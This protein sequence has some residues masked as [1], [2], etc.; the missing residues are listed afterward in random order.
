MYEESY[1][2]AAKYFAKAN[3]YEESLENYWLFLNAEIMKGVSANTPDIITQIANLKDNVKGAKVKIDICQMAKTKPSLRDFYLVLDEAC[4]YLSNNEVERMYHF[5]WQY[6]I[7]QIISKLTYEKNDVHAMD[8]IIKKRNE[9]KEFGI[10]LDT[11]KLA[12][13]AYSLGLKDYAILFWE[14]LDKTMR[15]VEYYKAKVDTLSYPKKME[16]MEAAQGVN[17]RKDLLSEYHMNKSVPLNDY[18]KNILCN[19]I[20]SEKA[21]EYFRE[22]LPYMLR[23]SLTMEATN[24]LL[25]EA[26]SVYKMIEL[27]VDVLKS[28]VAAKLTDLSTWSTPKTKYAD[29]KA[30]EL[31]NAISFLRRIRTSDYVNKQLGRQL[32]S[33]ELNSFCTNVMRLYAQRAFSPV[34]YLEVGRIIEL[35]NNFVE[36][37][38]YYQNVRSM[39]DD[40]TF[41]K[42]VDLRII[43]FLERIAELK[44][45]EQSIAEAEAM[46]KSM[47]LNSDFVI[48]TISSVSATD[49]EGLI[50]YAL[51]ISSEVAPERE[52]RKRIGEAKAE[53]TKE[54]LIEVKA[55]ETKQA[56][57][58]DEGTPT[59]VERS[60]SKQTFK[61]GEYELTYTPRKDE[62][63]IRYEN[64]D[65]D[66]TTK[67]KKGVL[68]N[69]NEFQLVD[70]RLYIT[71]IDCQTPFV[72]SVVE[73]CQIIEIYD[74][75]KRTGIS[76][77]IEKYSN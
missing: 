32:P 11:G 38:N 4:R 45:D 27:N 30:S 59:S 49:W 6:S 68:S 61:Y 71:E 12:I 39:F 3:M 53:E 57:S 34:I 76:F 51:T 9:L 70:N 2:Q 19:V 72:V 17:W 24:I 74:G 37:K 44:N 10:I 42:E 16:F 36:S 64:G 75:E 5:A 63:I 18:Q 14:E 65:D 69:I 52:R 33:K 67:I 66:Y 15:P 28:I 25:D 54:S 41:R 77:V 23:S 1:E 20:R 40:A 26:V 73:D 21:E 60:T 13:K 58:S 7:N 47:R 62:V 31:F 29:G 8:T 48:P 22:F 35:R 50:K 46:R 43:L 55:E 56:Q